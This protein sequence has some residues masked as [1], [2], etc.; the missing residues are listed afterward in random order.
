MSGPEKVANPENLSQTVAL[1]F[2]GDV[3]PVG[4]SVA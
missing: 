2:R 3:R 4:V 1:E